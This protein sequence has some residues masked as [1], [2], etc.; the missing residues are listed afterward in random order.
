MSKKLGKS[1]F[2]VVGLLPT[3]YA[4]EEAGHKYLYGDT[5]AIKRET[6]WEWG[7]SL[8][9]INKCEMC[10]P[11]KREGCGWVV[12][13]ENIGAIAAIEDNLLSDP[14]QLLDAFFLT[15]KSREIFGLF[16]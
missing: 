11:R 9:K 12:E 8:V 16:R 2:S 13:F 3:D 14:S 10:G 7:F 6:M 15:W 1:F 5:L 4:I